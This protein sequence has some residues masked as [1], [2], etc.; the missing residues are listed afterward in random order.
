MIKKFLIIAACLFGFSVAAQAEIITLSSEGCAPTR[1]CFNVPNN[2]GLDITITN[3]N[4]TFYGR[5]V[6]YIGNDMYDS[7]LYA[8]PNLSDAV[9]Y[10]SNGNPLHVSISFTVVRG[11]CVREGRAT[12]CPQYVTLNGGTLTRP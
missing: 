10:D 12:V 9:I 3:V 5:L 2:E 8:F 7:G 1:I 4:P 6:I 11:P